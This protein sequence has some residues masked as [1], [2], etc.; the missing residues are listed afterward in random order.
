MSSLTLTYISLNDL[1][2]KFLIGNSKKHDAD[3]LKE[4][5]LKYGF[6][7]PVAIDKNLNNGNGGIIEGNGRIEALKSLFDEDYLPPKNIEVRDNIWYVPVIFGG[8]ADDE[9]SAIAFS[10]E[11][12]LSVLWG[13]EFSSEEMLKL[14]DAEAIASQL[15]ELMNTESIPITFKDNTD[16]ILS[17]LNSDDKNADSVFPFYDDINESDVEGQLN[18][19]NENVKKSIIIEYN[20][21]DYGMVKPLYDSIKKKGIDIGKILW[22]ELKKHDT[23]K[24]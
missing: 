13:S 7:D 11:H 14:F 3:R 6:R 19:F 15:S 22:D 16:E 21:E 18:N 20:V 23:F 17:L 5:Y 12:N 1:V 4:S 2:S 24:N 10:I 8:D 9:Q